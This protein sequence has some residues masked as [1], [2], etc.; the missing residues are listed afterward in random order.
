MKTEETKHTSLGF[1]SYLATS[2][3]GAFNDNGF[4]LLLTCF[5]MRILPYEM[6]KTYVPLAGFCFA[7][8]YLVCSSYAGWLS[9]RYRKSSVFVWAKWLE[10]AVMGA[11]VLFFRLNAVW[12]LLGVLF[13]MGTQSAIYSPAKYGY[14]PEM[15]NDAELSKENGLTQMFTFIAIIAGTWAG[16]M[17]AEVHNENW[18]IG[19]LYCVVVA[20]L[21]VLTSYFI[22]RTPDGNPDA[23]LCLNPLKTHLETWRAVSKDPVIILSMLGNTYFWFVAAL[24]QNN[25]PLHVKYVLLRDDSAVI[26]YLLGAVGLGIALGALCC[27]LLSGKRIGYHLI[28]PSGMLMGAVCI[29][30]GLSGKSLP[31][32]VAASTLLGFFAGMYQLPLSTALQKHSPPDRR[33]SCLALGN[34]VDCVSMI[35]A[36]LLQWLLMS[37]F[38]LNASGVF[39][40]LGLITIGVM[41]Y[42]AFKAPFLARRT[43]LW[44]H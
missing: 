41:F 27:G 26:G 43:L 10:L 25:L 20:L 33:G 42:I 14:L 2:F 7:L 6:Q 28:V 30:A 18:W 19:G 22:D 40:V 17:I 13:L 12:C 11:G 4:K 31:A 3:F 1:A 23:V 35:L 21:G 34:G 44:R 36:Y 16:G 15:L 8:P 24:F 37:L 32:A 38:R 29:M 5:A 39:V 9:D